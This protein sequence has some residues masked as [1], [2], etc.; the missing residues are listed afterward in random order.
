MAVV[1]PTYPVTTLAQAEDM[2]IFTGNQIH[3]IMNADATS[4][5][6]AED[7]AI[8]S[9]RKAFVDN[10]YFKPPQDWVSSTQVTDPLQLKQFT[11]GGWY[12]APTATASTPVTLGTTPIGDTNWK[13]WNKDQAAVYQHA[14]RLAAEAGYNI[15]SGSFYFGGT[16]DSVDD[17]LFY[18]GDG[19]YYS[20]T[21]SFPKVVAAG[22][23]PATSGGVGAGAWV[24]RTDD[25]LRD[26]LEPRIETS[27][28]NIEDLE[29]RLL[30]VGAKIYR[31]S[32]GQY[33]QNGD[34]VPAETTHL[35]VLINGKVEDVA[36]SPVANGTVSL[37]TE[38]GATIG[39]LSVGFTKAS[40]PTNRFFANSVNDML[41]G[42][43]VGG[44]AG[45]VSHYA[46][47]VWITNSYHEGG[48]VGGSEYIITSDVTGVDEIGE[49]TI[50]DFFAVFHKTPNSSFQFGAK[51]YRNYPT[52]DS[53]DNIQAYADYCGK[54]LITQNETFGIFRITKSIYISQ[55]II[56][57]PSYSQSNPHYDTVQLLADNTTG[58][59]MLKPRD[60]LSTTG[61]HRLPRIKN[62]NFDSVQYRT[63]DAI[64]GRGYSTSL[65]GIRA[66][67]MRRFFC[68][69]GVSI[70]FKDCYVL[71]SDVGCELLQMSSSGNPPSTQWKF[72]GQCTFHSNRIGVLFSK[73]AFA[74]NE[75]S[76]YDSFITTT[77]YY[78]RHPS[79][80][81]TVFEKN[82]EY[83][84]LSTD[85]QL[86][87]ASF[88][89]TW[90]ESN[91]INGVKTRGTHS[92]LTVINNRYETDTWDVDENSTSGGKYEVNGATLTTTRVSTWVRRNN[93]LQMQTIQLLFKKTGTTQ[94]SHYT[95]VNRARNNED[96]ALIGFATLHDYPA[97]AGDNAGE[98]RFEINPYPKDGTVIRPKFAFADVHVVS[99]KNT[100]AWVREQ[101]YVDR[102]SSTNVT[103][104]CKWTNMFFAVVDKDGKHALPDWIF[105]TLT[106]DPA[107]E[108]LENGL[109]GSH[110]PFVTDE[111]LNDATSNINTVNKYALKRN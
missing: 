46:G 78:Q 13:P 99:D 98:I 33:V 102:Y 37:I 103:N 73:D 25:S 47:Q 2:I 63:H 84:L 67:R 66:N 105:I 61:P 3:D 75:S 55:P 106:Y 7:G 100:K 101:H 57:D 28:K 14:K 83:G 34:V 19:K 39:L 51:N 77:R 32:N 8:P 62:I 108:E 76:E 44:N 4:V 10:M 92:R 36:M 104:N 26:E 93:A 94:G 79:F 97:S 29:E 88:Y 50:G 71:D 89:N 18:E 107:Q 6:E 20:W 80:Y 41:I 23:T 31:G 45:D 85:V 95:Q 40:I 109:Q 53:S 52:Y 21:G 24:D 82:T 22:S 12:F 96:D 65:E 59:T 69:S 16:L 74:D 48:S 38:I 110:A 87:G 90:T 1:Y 111:E 64:R 56:C 11:D 5:I 17:V 49:F 68:G 43:P 9:I 54:K 15:V 91:G 72:S 81:N 70:E 27:E 30:G 35:R 58:F 86:F 42:K 60:S